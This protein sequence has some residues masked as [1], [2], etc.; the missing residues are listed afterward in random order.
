MKIEDKLLLREIQKRNEAVFEALFHDYY[1]GLVKFAEGFVFDSEVCED[2]VQN[3]FV[4]IWE[5]AEYLNITSSFKSYLYQAVK[6]R[7]LNYLRN[8]KIVDKHH[9]LYIEASINDSNVNLE[10]PELIQKIEMAIESLPPKMSEIFRLKYLEE[11]TIR[12][13]SSQLEIT[14]NTIKTQLLRAKDKLR[15]G[16]R[17]SLDINFLL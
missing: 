1:S 8:L 12:E 17:E 9:L 3:I 6:N 11:K 15:V 2:I 10:N 5:Q 7:C 16:L 14:E 13:I 4:Y